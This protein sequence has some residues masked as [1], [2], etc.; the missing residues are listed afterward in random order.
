MSELG[1]KNVFS[2]NIK[3]FME[4]NNVDRYKLAD[5][6][7]IK[8]TTLS[9]WINGN[10]YP[11]IDKIELLANYFH[12]NKSSLIEEWAFED[13]HTN[14][15]TVKLM[16]NKLVKLVPILGKVPAGMPMEA[17]ENEYTI[18]Y[19]TIPLDWTK[20]NK[21]YFALKIQGN[22]MEPVYKNG[23]TVIFLQTP[24]FE[25]GQDCCVRINGE[26][27]TFKRITKKDNGI[28]LTPL[29]ID[30]D[31]GFLPILYTYEDMEKTPIEIL[32]VAKRFIQDI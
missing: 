20:G 32:G 16:N 26:E 15:S 9:D 28:L 30:N 14:D 17:I 18:D 4:I 10:S 3:K 5:A 27:A 29:N 22:S 21:K 2:K 23:S 24:N 13:E 19:E 1:N 11:R 8:Y 31:T 6:L 12:V 25:S 7:D